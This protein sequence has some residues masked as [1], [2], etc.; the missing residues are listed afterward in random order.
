MSLA[1]RT[2]TT[3]GG[4]MGSTAPPVQATMSGEDAEGSDTRVY[5]IRSTVLGVMG[6]SP[7]AWVLLPSCLPQE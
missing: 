2:G 1:I 4:G 5:W 3:G 6:N 7:Q